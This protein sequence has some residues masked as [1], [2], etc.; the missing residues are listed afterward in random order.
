MFFNATFESEL[1]KGKLFWIWSAEMVDNG[2]HLNSIQHPKNNNQ[3][4][5]IACI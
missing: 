5:E 1:E 2:L 4:N 3:R